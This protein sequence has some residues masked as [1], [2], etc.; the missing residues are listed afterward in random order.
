MSAIRSTIFG[1]TRCYGMKVCYETLVSS[2]E[3]V[4]TDT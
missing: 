1:E 4:Q 3:G 2:M